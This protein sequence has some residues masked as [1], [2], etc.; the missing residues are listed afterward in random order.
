MRIRI[1]ALLSALLWGCM[2]QLAH[3]DILVVVNPDNDVVSLTEN[4]V[5]RLFLG[6]ENRFPNGRRAMPVD[7]GDSEAIKATFYDEISNKSLSQLKSYWSRRIFNGRAEPPQV[8]SGDS[9]VKDF[10]ADNDNAIAYIDAASID[11]SVKVV[12][13]ITD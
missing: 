5:E 7:Q 10:V 1:L 8:V 6:K 11:D 4:Q 13:V 2:A 12:L 9:S 3:A